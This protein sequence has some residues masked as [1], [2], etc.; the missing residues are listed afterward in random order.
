MIWF[1]LH[2]THVFLIQEQINWQILTLKTGYLF[3]LAPMSG[4][5]VSRGGAFLGGGCIIF[6]FAD[7]KRLSFHCF[8]GSSGAW[9]AG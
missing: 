3:F 9:I 2:E 8:V 5:G 1:L 6:I 7:K 4:G